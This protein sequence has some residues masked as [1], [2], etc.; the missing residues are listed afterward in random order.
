MKTIS[1]ITI[2]IILLIIFAGCASMPLKPLKKD[3]LSGA[4]DQTA[5]LLFDVEIISHSSRLLDEFAWNIPFITIQKVEESS[6]IPV[7][8]SSQFKWNFWTGEFEE[9]TWKVDGSV[10]R[11]E[12]SLATEAL[13]G[14]YR[15]FDINFELGSVTSYGYDSSTTT[16]YSHHFYM[17]E[18][19]QV[20]TPGIYT[21]GKIVLEIIDM[22]G[23]F[24]NYGFTYKLFIEQDPDG[25]FETYKNFA[26]SYPQLAALYN[27]KAAQ[28]PV[29]YSYIY[30]FSTDRYLLW[31]APW[32]SAAG[33]VVDYQYW[34]GKYALKKK[35][36]DGSYYYMR[37]TQDI[38][39]PENCNLC[40]KSQ[41]VEG[42]GEN[43]AGLMFGSE[44]NNCYFFTMLPDGRVGVGYLKEGEWKDQLFEFSVTG[45]YSEA[46]GLENHHRIEKRGSKATYYLNDHK[47]LTFKTRFT[48]DYPMF[49]FF[50]A[51]KGIVTFDDFMITGVLE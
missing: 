47:V 4:P 24:P 46:D 10:H 31:N 3:I 1:R 49:A 16:T 48:Q 33:K 22:R 38:Y 50:T 30:N 32:D 51:G 44:P 36:S 28:A 20:Q 45:G 26:G 14:E 41:I 25:M 35:I 37:N 2:C 17:N 5:V 15:F 27:F 18:G 29:Y 7:E 42:E 9:E 6:L 23:D 8:L 40:W 13:C 21:L 19:F 43:G 39:M 34:N 12:Y 11:L